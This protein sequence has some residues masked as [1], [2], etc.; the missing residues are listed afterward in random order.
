MKKYYKLILGLGLLVVWIGY[1]VFWDLS[2]KDLKITASENNPEESVLPGIP[3]DGGEETPDDGGETED[4][5][6]IRITPDLS[7]TPTVVDAK[8]P[9]GETT[10]EPTEEPTPEPTEEPT[11]EPTEEPTPEPTEPPEPAGPYVADFA[12]ANVSTTLNIRSTPSTDGDILGSLAADAWGFVLER[13]DEWTKIKSGNVTGYARSEF[14]MFDQTAITRADRLGKFYIEISVDTLNIRT[15]KNTESNVIKEAK[16]GEKYKVIT[17]ETDNQWIAVV[18][19]DTTNGFVKADYV[20][21]S[22][23]LP[24]AVEITP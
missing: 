3:K 13:G 22:L 6:D 14:L 23:D 5:D 18:V 12:I 24:L 11:P 4:E 9:E 7:P 21:T 20:V 17:G 2:M 1:I 15:E 10:P 8:T 19:D 16:K